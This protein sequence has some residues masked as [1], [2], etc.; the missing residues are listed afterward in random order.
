MVFR[1]RVRVSIILGPAFEGG[2]NLSCDFKHWNLDSD[3]VRTNYFMMEIQI[4]TVRSHV[5]I[6]FVKKKIKRMHK[7][8]VITSFK[9]FSRPN[10]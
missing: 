8:H 2:N 6:N 3:L 7:H 4:Q 1:S 10:I 9:C 5:I